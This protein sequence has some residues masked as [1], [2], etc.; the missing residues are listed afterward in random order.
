M[1]DAIRRRSN[2]NIP[3]R[4][5]CILVAAAMLPLAQIICITVFT[6]ACAIMFYALIGYPLLL[7]WLAKHEYIFFFCVFRSVCASFSAQNR[8]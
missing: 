7:D 3:P 2:T 6:V 4:G 8:A 1:L 5:S